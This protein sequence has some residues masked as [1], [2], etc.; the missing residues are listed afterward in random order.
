MEIPLNSHFGLTELETP[1][2]VAL[3]TFLTK[4]RDA[5]SI[6]VN[7]GDFLEQGIIRTTDSD[8]EAR[9]LGQ[10]VAELLGVSQ[11][12]MNVLHSSWVVPHLGKL[13]DSL[14]WVNRKLQEELTRTRSSQSVTEDEYR[15]SVEAISE[16]ERELERTTR[17]LHELSSLKRRTDPVKLAEWE[18]LCRSYVIKVQNLA[19]IN[20]EIKK[21]HDARI[22]RFFPDNH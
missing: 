16:K 14:E 18:A 19:F 4:C 20:H 21:K 5:A 17:R 9:E 12:L 6:Y 1:T 2:M 7:T 3:C 15:I 8:E 10:K 11:Q 13:G 22:A